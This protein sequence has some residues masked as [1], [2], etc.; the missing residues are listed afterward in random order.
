[1]NSK[2]IIVVTVLILSSRNYICLVLVFA[3]KRE[4]EELKKEGTFPTEEMEETSHQDG[5]L[6]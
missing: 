3:E 6:K 4:M 5:E 1:M 2:R